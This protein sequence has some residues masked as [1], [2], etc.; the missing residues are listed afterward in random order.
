MKQ[1]SLSRPLT[2]E[3]RKA[4]ITDPF[5]KKCCRASDEC[6]GRIT[7]EHA[8]EYAGR[9]VD[10]VWALIPL[11]EYHHG[12]K[13]EGMNK[14]ENIRIAMSRATV[15]DRVKYSRLRWDLQ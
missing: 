10:D 14:R 2:A 5:Y 7:I 15:T 3:A 6:D 13:G 12:L 8:I 1:G 4:I 11:C 9:R